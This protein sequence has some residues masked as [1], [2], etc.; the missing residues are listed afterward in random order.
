MFLNSC[1][2]ALRHDQH[3]ADVFGEHFVDD[4]D[5]AVGEADAAHGLVASDGVGVDGAVD[6]VGGVGG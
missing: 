4:V 3:A 1:D 6:A 5:V 2:I